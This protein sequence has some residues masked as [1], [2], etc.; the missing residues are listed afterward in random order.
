M[1]EKDAAGPARVELELPEGWPYIGA[2]MINLETH[3][4]ADVSN[5]KTAQNRVVVLAPK[6]NW[7]VMAFYLDPTL[8]PAS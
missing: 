4:R 8:R 2:V 6:G 1:V 7:K 3:E 5:G